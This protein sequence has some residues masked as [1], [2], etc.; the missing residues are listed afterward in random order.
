MPHVR[1]TKFENKNTAFYFRSG[2]VT[3]KFKYIRCCDVRFNYLL[4]LEFIAFGAKGKCF[5]ATS[6]LLFARSLV[7]L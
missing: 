5:Y 2:G 3:T 6:S 7:I 4:K 1:S